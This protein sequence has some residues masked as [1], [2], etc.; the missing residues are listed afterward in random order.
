MDGN[1][2]GAKQPRSLRH[3]AVITSRAPDRQ[4]EGLA[5]GARAPLAAPYLA[6]SNNAS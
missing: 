5:S 6:R 2:A 3:E 1:R 4:R